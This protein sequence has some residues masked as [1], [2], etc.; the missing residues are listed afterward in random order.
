MN[1]INNIFILRVDCSYP[2]FYDSD[3]DQCVETCPQ[4][5]F[6]VVDRSDN[7]TMRN[8]STRELAIASYRY[9]FFAERRV[10]PTMNY[11]TLYM[12]ELAILLLK[13]T[14]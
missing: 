5:T 7:T 9:S 12:H 13:I 14:S 3:S 10:A 1:S 4:G 6:G 11:K 8:C 2:T